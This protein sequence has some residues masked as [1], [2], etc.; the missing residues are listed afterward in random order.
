M[1]FGIT[2]RLVI[3]IIRATKP[4]RRAENFDVVLTLPCRVGLIKRAIEADII[5]TPGSIFEAESIRHFFPAQANE[6]RPVYYTK[7]TV[8][9]HADSCSALDY[10]V[11]F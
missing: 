5:E 9:L 2:V 11:T 3:G 7:R 1:R 6:P 4:T 10:H 8:W